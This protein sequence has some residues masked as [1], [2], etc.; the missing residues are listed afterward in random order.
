M[1][2]GKRLQDFAD[3][4]RKLLGGRA[5]LVSRG[6]RF[7]G[8]GSRLLGRGRLLGGGSRLVSSSRLLGGE[9]RVNGDNLLARGWLLLYSGSVLGG[10]SSVLGGSVLGSCSVLGSR[11]LG[12][13]GVLSSS[14]VLSSRVLGSSSSV[15]LG[16]SRLLSSND[17]DRDFRVCLALN[18]GE[19]R[20][21]AI[22]LDHL[23][24]VGRLV[25][26]QRGGK[27]HGRSQKE[28]SSAAGHCEG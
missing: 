22:S 3:E 27:S 21:H 24:G 28:D 10:S 13:R 16:G 23:S 15:L 18:D 1:G 25:H 19:V 5:R 17:H 14:C 11:V 2:G 8:G 26:C 9:E 20:H 12:G 6:R 4:G 7:L